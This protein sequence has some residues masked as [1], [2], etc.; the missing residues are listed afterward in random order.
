MSSF[1]LLALPITTSSCGRTYCDFYSMWVCLTK[2]LL[3]STLSPVNAFQLFAFII[4][5]QMSSRCIIRNPGRRCTVFLFFF[6]ISTNSTLCIS[7]IDNTLIKLIDYIKKGVF[8]RAWMER[9]RDE[10]P[11]G[12]LYSSVQHY[13]LLYLQ[14]TNFP[15]FT[16]LVKSTLWGNLKFNI[17]WGE[18]IHHQNESTD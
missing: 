4:E 12:M 18:L 13:Y 17:C 9:G 3:L 6:L 1:L 16:A 2:V 15:G 14:V 11:L 10:Q 7:F 8:T 5:I